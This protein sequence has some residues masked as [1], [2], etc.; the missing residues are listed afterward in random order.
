MTRT[1]LKALLSM[2]AALLAAGVALVGA[3][4][5]TAAIRRR[6]QRPPTVEGFAWEEQPEVELESGDKNPKLY[7]EYEGLY[8]AMIEEIEGARERTTGYHTVEVTVT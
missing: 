5:A 7:P 8:E 4:E 3:V 2:L 1:M 6:G